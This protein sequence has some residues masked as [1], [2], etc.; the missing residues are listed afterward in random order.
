MPDLYISVDI[1]SDGPI[2]GPF[3]MLSMGACTV[4]VRAEDGRFH[5][6]ESPDTFYAE[7]RPVGD[8]F[9]R[10]ALAV[11]GL[12]RDLLS[13]H[14]QDP[15]AAMEQFGTWAAA[16]ADRERATAV[17]CA[18]PLGFD[19]MFVRHYF[20]LFAPDAD[21]FGHSNA[22]DMKSYF[23]AHARG[24]VAG[25]TKAQLPEALRNRMALSH[26]ALEDATAQA[27][28]L[29]AMIADYER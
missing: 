7:L 5:P 9:D 19:W 27:G 26:N 8:K 10:S 21:P 29:R 28:L 18:W 17:F 13:V 15:A 1:E 20:V 4:G 23:L 12:D 16:I 2:P 22:L 3:S 24:T 11:S 14:G 6:T 25:S